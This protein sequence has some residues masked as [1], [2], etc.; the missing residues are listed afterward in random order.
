[1]ADMSLV[2]YF[3]LTATVILLIVMIAEILSGDNR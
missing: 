1:M 3:G 2:D